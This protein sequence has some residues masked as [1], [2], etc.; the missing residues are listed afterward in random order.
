MSLIRD[1]LA[2]MDAAGLL[3]DESSTSSARLLVMKLEGFAQAGDV[4]ARGYLD[5]F[6]HEGARREVGSYLKSVRMK[7]KSASGQVLSAPS[8]LGV[9]IKD[10][11]TGTR[12]GE[13]QYPLLEDLSRADLELLENS[14]GRQLAAMGV[15]IAAV[16][17]CLK[18]LDRYPSAN[19]VREALSMAGV[20]SLEELTG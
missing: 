3:D 20:Q 5:R 8:R 13:Y 10:A 2:E 19:T 14:V 1:L 4:E 12:T 15:T 7:F 6:V 11:K 18:V 9:P 16:R 17:Q